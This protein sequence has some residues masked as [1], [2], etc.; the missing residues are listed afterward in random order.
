[1]HTHMH[2]HSERRVRKSKI[3]FLWPFRVR[4]AH[5]FCATFSR[6][7]R[8]YCKLYTCHSLIRCSRNQFYLFNR[9]I[10]WNFIKAQMVSA[11]VH[12]HFSCKRKQ[13]RPSIFTLASL[14][15]GV[16]SVAGCVWGPCQAFIYLLYVTKVNC[17]TGK[18]RAAH[19]LQVLIGITHDAAADRQRQKIVWATFCARRSP[20]LVTR[21]HTR[22]VHRI[23][24]FSGAFIFLMLSRI[25]NYQHFC[26][27]LAVRGATKRATQRKMG[28]EWCGSLS[29]VARSFSASRP[30]SFASLSKRLL[31]R[32]RFDITHWNLP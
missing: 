4:W 17:R 22:P 29:S 3:N 18:K 23:S 11:T 26:I 5:I 20:L 13:K 16:R 9:M 14:A 27:S 7:L 12:F 30:V 6:F 2:T 15:G 21:V 32:Q 1:M 31:V 8:I 19:E 24:P 10:D 28:H 25:I